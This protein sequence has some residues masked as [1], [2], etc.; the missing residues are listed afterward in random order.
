VDKVFLRYR[1]EE[2]VRG[3]EV[4][5]LELIR[6]LVQLGIPL[7]VP[8]VSGWRERLR[9]HVAEADLTLW[10]APA[11]RLDPLNGWWCAARR[12][13]PRF[14][15]LIIGNVGKG[16]LPM[17]RLLARRGRFRKAVL[18]A[19]REATDGFAR[20][21]ATMPGTVVAVN[22]QIANRFR[23]WGHPHVVVDYGVTHGDWFVPRPSSDW[24]AD[25]VVHF[26]VVGWL[27][28]AWKGADTALAAFRR[29][30][31]KVRD[32]SMLHLA[33]YQEP[34]SFP[35]AN[36]R[37]YPWM[38]FQAMP[39]FLRTMDVLIVPSR[40]EDV[41]RE[42]FCQAMVQGMLTGLPIVANRL[43]ILE[44][45][46]DRG[47]GLSVD[48][49]DAMAG[50]MTRLCLEPS[51]R[52]RLGREGRAVALERYV[53]D[54]ARFVRRYLGGEAFEKAADRKASVS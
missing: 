1:E 38:P 30:P 39:A 35:E 4:F 19:H 47:G 51:L 24:T 37:A 46:L 27:D 26:A 2:P 49:V 50:A 16:L 11:T 10:E 53:W 18:I 48:S 43:P 42:T 54:T 41:M 33:S 31:A 20:W 13:Q 32:R 6:D 34:S 25:P 8:A 40:D 21:M 9:R 22:R 14:E 23:K 5:N 44:E 15:T 3:V 29:M 36:I 7:T 12:G 17:I 52:E 28:N 45:K